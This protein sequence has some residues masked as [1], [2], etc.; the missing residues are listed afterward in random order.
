MRFFR[1]GKKKIITALADD[2]GC[3]VGGS[4]AKL[5]VDPEY[6]KHFVKLCR[7]NY[8]LKKFDSDVRV[9]TDRRKRILDQERIKRE[10]L[11]FFQKENG[12]ATTIRGEY[13]R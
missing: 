12:N 5:V 1:E 6:R 3:R 11:Y 7:A 2:L 8:L 4:D 13:L 9:V 10:C